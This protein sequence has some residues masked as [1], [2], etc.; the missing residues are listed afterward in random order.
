MQTKIDP[1]NIPITESPS[2]E[3][4]SR[5]LETKW[6]TSTQTSFSLK[7]GIRSPVK[8]SAAIWELEVGEW[9]EWDFEM[10]DHVDDVNENKVKAENEITKKERERCW[11][12]SPTKMF[13]ISP[14]A[15]K[16]TLP[17]PTRKGP[18]TRSKSDGYLSK[19][20]EE[21]ESKRRDSSVQYSDFQKDTTLNDNSIV[22][23]SKQNMVWAKGVWDM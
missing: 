8:R 14:T 2:M 10:T 18:M 16:F 11:S 1:T 23:M 22:E 7:N 20:W 6:S 13:K 5:I 12:R 21:L 4:L 17:S 19:L 15:K 9:D 3:E